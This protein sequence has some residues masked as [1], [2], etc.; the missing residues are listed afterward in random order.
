MA[1]ACDIYGCK[2][3]RDRSARLCPRCAA[4]LPEEIALGIAEALH[5][6]RFNDWVDLRK[7]AAA[8]LN[9]DRQTAKAPPPIATITPQR[10]YDM[11]A[12][13]LG[14]RPEA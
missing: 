6:R 12:R 7:R 8:F 13:M 11:Q 4:R 5:Q 14:E 3:T 9:L 2:G 10:A 1:N